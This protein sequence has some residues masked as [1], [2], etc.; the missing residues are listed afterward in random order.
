MCPIR[1][2]QASAAA[3]A[4]GVGG[5][6][7][8]DA[9]PAPPGALPSPTGRG[10]AAVTRLQPLVRVRYGL[11]I[12]QAK[13]V[14]KRGQVRVDGAVVADTARHVPAGA[15]VELLPVANA[16]AAADSASMGIAVVATGDAGPG[17]ASRWLV[18]WKPPGIATDDL[19]GLLRPL[20]DE[21]DRGAAPRVVSRLPKVTWLGPLCGLAMA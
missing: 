18:A 13:Q 11:T 21:K 10:A 15:S 1:R 19:P 16:H 4:A 20:L 6:A 17:V 2:L 8:A 5:V 3:A 12:L 7:D 9:A 14:I